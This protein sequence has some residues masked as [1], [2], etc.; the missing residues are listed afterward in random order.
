MLIVSAVCVCCVAV[1]A[2]LRKLKQQSRESV[3]DKRPRLLKALKEVKKHTFHCRP[4]EHTLYPCVM[5]GACGSLRETDPSGNVLQTGNDLQ[6]RRLSVSVLC[7]SGRSV[8]S[9]L[10][11][12]L[13]VSR[14]TPTIFDLFTAFYSA[15]HSE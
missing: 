8:M 9:Q 13:F 7:C 2:L 6:D 10:F 14:R 11:Y 5:I 12:D 3:E 15:K 1:T 4:S